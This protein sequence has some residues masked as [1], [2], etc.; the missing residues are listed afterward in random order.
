MACECCCHQPGCCVHHSRSDSDSQ[1]E[2]ANVGPHHS[3]LDS[4]EEDPEVEVEVPVSSLAFG[5]ATRAALVAMDRVDL[6]DEFLTRACVI[7]CVPA[8]L[9]GLYRASMRFVLIEADRARKTSDTVTLSRAWK[10]FLILPR[11]LLHRPPRGGNIPKCRLLQRFSDFAAGQWLHLL[12]E[13]RDFATQASVVSHRRRWR[14]QGDDARRR[15]DHAE[16]QMGELSAGRAALAP[17]N[18]I[19]TPIGAP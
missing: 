17:G 6:E 12:E 9:R 7:Q 19:Q 10:L 1:V 16:V 15:A 14:L 3:D 2:V 11:L 13:S 18:E 8:F 5:A 4:G